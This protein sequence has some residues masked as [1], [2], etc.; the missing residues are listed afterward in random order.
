RLIGADL[1]HAAGIDGIVHADFTPND[2]GPVFTVT[3]LAGYPPVD[4]DG[5]DTVLSVRDG[6]FGRRT[7]V[8]RRAYDLRRNSVTMVDGFEPGRTY[9]L[10]YRSKDPAVSGLGLAAVRDVSSW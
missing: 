10:S 8:D 4:S 2:A 5:A 1:P 6:P 3:D 7:I 9:E